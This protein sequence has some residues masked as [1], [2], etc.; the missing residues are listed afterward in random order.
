[1]K[2]TDKKYK[3]QLKFCQNFSVNHRRINTKRAKAD[4]LPLS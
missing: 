1:M 4:V 3:K 2:F